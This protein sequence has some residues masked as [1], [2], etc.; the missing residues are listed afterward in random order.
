MGVWGPGADP[1][2]MGTS[3][4]RTQVAA[5]GKVLQSP[6][7]WQDKRPRLYVW[8]ENRGLE[9]LRASG[10]RVVLDTPGFVQVCTWS[11]YS[12]GSQF[13]NSASFGYAILDNLAYEIARARLG[14]QEPETLL[15]TVFLSHKARIES[16][17]PVT[18]PTG[19]QTSG[20]PTQRT[21]PSG[22]AANYDAEVV[23]YLTAPS[24]TDG[25][26]VTIGGVTTNFTAPAGRATFRVPLVADGTP[27]SVTVFRGGSPVCS[28]A[29]S[30][31]VRSQAWQYNQGTFVFG[32]NRA[33]TQFDPTQT[34]TGATP[35]YP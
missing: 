24:D 31:T 32:S 23:T 33:V 6:F 1:A 28:V 19:A 30:V 5:A 2:I 7:W 3:T 20:F 15:D 10:N 17:T 12:E 4:V 8:T 25:V 18:S 21:W 13:A 35:T 16:T 9:C 26:Q 27:P 34:N 29:S 11:D 22:S 14:G